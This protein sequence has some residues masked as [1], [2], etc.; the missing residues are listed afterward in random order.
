VVLWKTEVT[1]QYLEFM[2][3][4]NSTSKPK[5]KE[6]IAYHF[7]IRLIAKPKRQKIAADFS[8]P[9]RLCRHVQQ[10]KN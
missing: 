4:N 7:A 10:M 8:C 9:Q 1:S 5:I 6:V 3:E 2:L